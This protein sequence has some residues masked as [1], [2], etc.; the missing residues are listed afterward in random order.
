MTPQLG[1]F[2]RSWVDPQQIELITT[3]IPQPQTTTTQA[4]VVG[5][6]GWIQQGIL[7]DPLT[8]R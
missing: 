3:T 1:K 2:T 7:I 5:L 4:V 6:Q 8:S